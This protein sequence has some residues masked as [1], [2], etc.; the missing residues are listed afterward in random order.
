MSF[1]QVTYVGVDEDHGGDDDVDA[2]DK[3]KLDR[4]QMMPP[5]AQEMLLELL[6]LEQQRVFLRKVTHGLVQHLKLLNLVLGA[7][8]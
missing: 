5:A 3:L 6:W 1:E 2:E 4:G 7:V 8:Q